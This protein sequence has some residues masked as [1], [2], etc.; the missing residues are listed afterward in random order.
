MTINPL[1]ISHEVP[2][3]EQRW[4]QIYAGTSL[5]DGYRFALDK[6]IEAGWSLR[7]AATL[8]QELARLCKPYQHDALG[9][10][11]RYDGMVLLWRPTGHSKE[12][13]ERA[14]LKNA[15]KPPARRQTAPPPKRA[16]KRQAR[17]VNDAPPIEKPAVKEGNNL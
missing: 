1:M 12:F 15:P 8:P 7:P 3:K 11:V 6:Y 14:P 5:E 2:N 10:G 9:D 13:G 4:V 17:T 16:A